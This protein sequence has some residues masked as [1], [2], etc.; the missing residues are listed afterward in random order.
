MTGKVRC[1]VCLVPTGAYLA[2]AILGPPIQKDYSLYQISYPGQKE[3][4][5]PRCLECYEKVEIRRR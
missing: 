1:P 5:S 4:L 3:Y 2:M